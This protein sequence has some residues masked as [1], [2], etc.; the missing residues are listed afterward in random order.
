MILVNLL[1]GDSRLFSELFVIH[2]DAVDQLLRNHQ[3]VSSVG[4]TSPISDEILALSNI[5]K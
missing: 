3:S 2:S 5:F 4:S 1:N